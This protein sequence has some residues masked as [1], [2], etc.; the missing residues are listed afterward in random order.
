MD[1]ISVIVPVYN[2]QDFLE[3]C[4]NSILN[5]T[6]KNIELILINDGS[7]DQSGRICNDFSSKDSRIKVIHQNNLGQA[8]AR[9]NGLKIA[10][11]NFIGF[12][13]SD[14]WIALNMYELLYSKAVKA[15]TDIVSC[16]IIFINREGRFKNYNTSQK[17]LDLDRLS[18]MKELISNKHL[19]FSACNKL[20]KKE[21]FNEVKF[22]EKTIFED[23][24][25]SY[26]LIHI[27]NSISYINYSLYFYR[28][29]PQ[30]TLRSN[31]SV[32]RLVEFQVKK[33]MYDF[34]STFYSELSLLA[35]YQLFQIGFILYARVKSQKDFVISDYKYLIQFD[36][37]ILKKIIIT[38]GFSI[39]KKIHIL[40][41]LLAP[42]IYIYFLVLELKIRKLVAYKSKLN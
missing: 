21:L 17:S 36:K 11:G 9:N 10:S 40:F 13:D 14:D 20:Y 5:Q 39:L 37:D 32:R 3:T 34:Y 15:N 38:R 7:S 26:R 22:D 2:T 31:M 33:K 18:A 35:Y 28:Y 41:Y 25:I 1:K 23:M 6:H 30:S 4:I 42:Y 27:S 12:V 19:T 16:N 29:N 24:D 8:A